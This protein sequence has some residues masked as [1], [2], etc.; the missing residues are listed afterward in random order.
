[1]ISQR[2]A[3]TSITLQVRL[4]LINSIVR[5]QAMTLQCGCAP[6]H[7]GWSSGRREGYSA[8]TI[9]CATAFMAISIVAAIMVQQRHLLAGAQGSMVAEVKNIAVDHLLVEGVLQFNQ[10]SAHYLGGFCFGVSD[11]HAPPHSAAQQLNVTLKN[12][13]PYASPDVR[14]Y[15]ML[16]D[17][18]PG[19]WGQVQDTFGNRACNDLRQLANAVSD[20]TRRERTSFNIHEFSI[21]RQWHALLV[22]CG[23][24]PGGQELLLSTPSVHD[25]MNYKMIGA[26][27]LTRWGPEETDPELCPQDFWTN[28]K[29]DMWRYLVA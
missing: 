2:P 9:V 27:A 17:D 15:L 21:S 5:V 7:Y 1:V 11:R 25:R 28:A 10:S 18:Q 4:D 20:M 13:N 8:R 14:L 23:R 29:Q 16:F 26:G 12:S 6:C 22:R 24:G 19:H 3:V